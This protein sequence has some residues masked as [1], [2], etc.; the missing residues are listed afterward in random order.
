M[1]ATGRII[2]VLP[3]MSGVSQRTGNNWCAQTYVL[4]TT[5]QYPKRIPFEVFG[6]D[7]IK[8]FGIQLGEEITIRFDVDGREWNGKWFPKISCFGVSRQNNQPQPQTGPQPQPVPQ[9]QQV[10]QPY[11]QQ[12]VVTQPTQQTQNANDGTNDLPF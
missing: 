1:E 9:P 5:E 11:A 3:A 12:Q 8:E 6:E 4:E 7:R 2:A 10:Q